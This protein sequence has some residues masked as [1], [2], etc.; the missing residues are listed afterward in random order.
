MY[1]IHVYTIIDETFDKKT[2][3]VSKCRIWAV[4]SRV[5]IYACITIETEIT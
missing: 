5:A 2:S 4:S 3:I 1:I